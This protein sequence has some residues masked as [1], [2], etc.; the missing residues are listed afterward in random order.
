MDSKARPRLRLD[1]AL[2]R[3][4]EEVLAFDPSSD[5]SYLFN[6]SAVAVLELCDGT[7]SSEDI[8]DRVDLA[9][10]RSQPALRSTVLD[11]LSDLLQRGVLESV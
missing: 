6:A 9:F 5:A 7:L 3:L 2:R 11:L 8:V 10:G 1:L 4:G